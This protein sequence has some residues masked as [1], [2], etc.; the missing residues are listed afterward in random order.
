MGPIGY[1]ESLVNNYHST[2]HNIGPIFKGKKDGTD[3]VK[4]KI[5][6]IGYCETSVHNYHSRLRKIPEDR[7]SYLHRGGS[8]KSRK[9]KMFSIRPNIPHKIPGVSEANHENIQ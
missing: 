3:W 8:L 6:P 9:H 5:G 7:R 2:V 1:P 4:K